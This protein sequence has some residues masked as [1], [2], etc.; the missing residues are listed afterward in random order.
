MTFYLWCVYAAVRPPIANTIASGAATGVVD[1]IYQGVFYSQNV[2]LFFGTRL[3]VIF[4]TSN[5][6]ACLRDHYEP[7]FYTE[8][9]SETRMWEVRHLVW[10][11]LRRY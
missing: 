11:T 5:K 4:F 8:F 6:Y 7:I 9:Y 2:T 10:L 1:R 3:N